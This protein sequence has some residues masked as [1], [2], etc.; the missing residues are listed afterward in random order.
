MATFF[1][2][3]KGGKKKKKWGPQQGGWVHHILSSIAR[4]KEKGGGGGRKH[5]PTFQKVR[6]K[7]YFVFFPFCFGRGRGRTVLPIGLRGGGKGHCLKSSAVENIPGEKKKRETSQR[8]QK[9]GRQV[10]LGGTAGCLSEEKRGE[11]VS[12]VLRQE[13]NA[14][15]SPAT[16]MSRKKKKGGLFHRRGGGQDSRFWVSGGK[17]EEGGPS[18]ETRK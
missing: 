2:L 16:R 12:V 9:K 8:A 1:V 7:D 14:V 13:K 5:P 18:A 15:G 10:E 11:G 4:G 6:K 17:K 3:D